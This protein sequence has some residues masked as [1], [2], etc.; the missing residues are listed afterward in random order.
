MSPVLPSLP[1][2]KYCLEM[3]DEF[4]KSYMGKAL[5]QKDCGRMFGVLVCTDGTVYR[6]FSGQLFNSYIHDGFVPPCFD[7]EALNS[8]LVEYDKKI[9]TCP[10]ESGKKALSAECWEKL[11]HLYKFYTF[12]GR[13]ITLADITL[14]V[15]SGTGDCC[16]PRLLSYCYKNKKKPLSLCEFYYGNGTKEHLSFHNPCD[17]RCKPI[18]KH[19]IGLD[20]VYLDDDIVVVNKMPEVLAIEGRGEDKT[21]C[22]ASRVRSLLGSIQQPCVHRLD[23]STS[24]L[25]VL[26]LTD[27]AHDR[28]SLDFENHKVYKEYEAL[29]EGKI[30]EKEGTITLPIRLDTDNRP[31]QIID[32]EKGK[33]A[34]TVWKNLGI[35]KYKGSFVTRLLL[36]PK[37]GR[38]H[39]LRVHCAYGL[40]HP[41][42]NDR[43]YG[44]PSDERLMLQATKLC[45]THPVT[46]KE[47]SFELAR[48]F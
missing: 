20:I 23:Q 3:I 11:C 48:D 29:A 18:L 6:A 36:I 14:A 26:G 41:I 9:K 45:F 40:K 42:L 15:P 31:H 39:Q 27:R 32:F 30:I 7:T 5:M 4:D 1:A 34:V 24:G 37:T 46:G 35:H 2:R 21:D 25:M 38:T 13:C 28:L 16:A 19:I 22:I 10:S 47:M 43:L 12:D 33:E 17:E 8:L 44:N